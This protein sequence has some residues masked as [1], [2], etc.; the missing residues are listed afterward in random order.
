MNEQRHV[1]WDEENLEKNAE[2]HRENPVTKPIDEPKT[3]FEPSR[4]L[5]EEGDFIDSDDEAYKKIVSG[6]PE[7][8]WDKKTMD[9]VR[10]A[11]ASV[12]VSV[13]EKEQKVSTETH[14]RGKRVRLTIDTEPTTDMKVNKD[15][16]LAKKEFNHMRKAVY[17]DEGAKFRALRAKL[18][19][20]EKE[21]LEEDSDEKRQSS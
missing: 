3:P 18:Q 20:E 7:E 14:A 5:D 13:D 15:E 8:L 4:Q 19:S 21:D 9:F 11:R 6:T 2:Y 1:V 10:R 12:P 17:A 16:S